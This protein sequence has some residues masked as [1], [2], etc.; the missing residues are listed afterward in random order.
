MSC[1]IFMTA[2]REARVSGREHTRLAGLLRDLAWRDVERHCDPRELHGRSLLRHALTLP[3]WVVRARGGEFGRNVE[4]FLGGDPGDG[5]VHLPGRR[6]A[7]SPLEVTVNT[8]ITGNPHPVAVAV[9]IAAQNQATGWVAAADR[10]WLA[11]LIQ[12]AARTPYPAVVAGTVHYGSTVLDEAA[13][14]NGTYEGWAGVVDL[15][16]AGDG[17]DVVLDSSKTDGFPDPTWAVAAD[18][19]LPTGWWQS[20]TPAQRWLTCLAGLHQ[21][22]AQVSPERRIAPDTLR[23]PQFGRA[24][25]TWQTVAAAW[26]DQPPTRKDPS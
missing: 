14:V 17:G 24:G 26:R 6:D 2:D 13:S 4:L 16:R 25:L 7:A 10:E 3:P 15:L 23:R 21:F 18:R 8:V 19:A 11:G 20:A 9:R 1:I 22:T 5:G 12:V